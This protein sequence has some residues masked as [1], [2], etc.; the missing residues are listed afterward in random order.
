MAQRTNRGTVL[1][2]GGGH[3]RV[4]GECLRL[5]GM[6]VG[7]VCD[8]DPTPAA[9]EP[10]LSLATLGPL[11]LL[12]SDPGFLASRTWMLALGSLELRRRLLDALEGVGEAI[13][14]IHPSAKVSP[15]AT[16]GEGTWVGPGAIVHTAAVVGEHAIVNSGAIVEHDCRVGENVHVAPG[17]AIGGDVRIGA[18][19]LVGI[20]ARVLPGVRIGAGCVIGVGAAVVN[21]LADGARVVGVPAK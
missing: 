13:S 18:D 19:T 2:G 11:S 1:L 12:I 5:I 7:G 20:G 4:V 8:D 17:A 9:G 15:S 21:D 6:P 10:P 16:I 14:A 3:A